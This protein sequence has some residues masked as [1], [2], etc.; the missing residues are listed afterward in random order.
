VSGLGGTG[1]VAD[2][3]YLM[4]HDEVTG[5]VLLSPRAAGLGLAAGLV[6]ELALAGAV[7]VT[8]GGLVV[9]GAAAPGD[10]LA[11]AVLGVVA[12]ERERPSV[13]DWLAFLGRTA[14]RDVAVRLAGAGYLASA[15]GWRG[16]RWVPVDADCAFAPVA[17]VRSALS[18]YRPVAGQ[19]VVVAG[20][21]DACGLGPRMT[22]YLPPGHHRRLEQS[23]ALLDPG[24]RV[25]VAATRAAVDSAV[26]CHRI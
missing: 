22:D 21:A 24:L 18:P 9:T 8:A 17:R 12:G 4:A 23:M 7:G 1:R 13:R 11:G 3:L 14:A 2:D 25:L 10:A 15:R 19:G 26:L 20:L 16:Q 6:A 5:R